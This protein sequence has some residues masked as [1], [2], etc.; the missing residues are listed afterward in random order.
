MKLKTRVFDIFRNLIRIAHF[1]R[2][3]LAYTQGRASNSFIC[4]LVPNNYQYPSGSMRRI[5]FNGINFEVDIHDVIGHYIYYAFQDPS[6]SNLFNLCKSG[7]TIID[8]GTNIGFA[9]LN[10]AKISG[11]DGIVIGFEPDPLNFIRLEKNIDLNNFTN[12]KINK[13]GLGDYRGKFKLENRIESN[14]GM[15][16][17]VSSDDFSNSDFTE[18]EIDT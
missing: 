14:S 3:L 4:K 8:I 13:K 9:L 5:E 7:D 6:L 18:V 1:D 2:I 10:M 12:L 15:K 16:R 17:I 11:P